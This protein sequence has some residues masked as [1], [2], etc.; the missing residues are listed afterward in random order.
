MRLNKYFLATT[1]FVVLIILNGCGGGSSPNTP[2]IPTSQ[3][4]NGPTLPVVTGDNVMKVTVNGTLCSSDVN[5]E[6]VNKP[7]VT[8]TVCDTTG[9]NCDTVDDV[10]LDTGSFG[11]RVFKSALTNSFSHLAAVTAGGN[12]VAECT[13]YGDNSIDWGPIKLAGVILGNEPVV[14]V[15][16]EVM[17]T[18]LPIPGSCHTSGTT[19]DTDPVNT[20]YKGILGVGLFA[21]DCGSSCVTASNNGVYYECPGEINCVSTA[22]PLSNQVTN[23]IALLP[24]DNNG[25][26]LELPSVKLGGLLSVNGYFVL[27]IG[28]RSN[29][30][31]TG[32]TAY[33][34]DK[35]GEFSTSFSSVTYTSFL[36]SGT[37]ALLFPG[38]TENG[39]PDCSGDYSSFFCPSSTVTL[40]AI[41]TASSGSSTSRINFQI[42]NTITLYNTVNYVFSEL[43]GSSTSAEGFDWGL[44]FFMGR[45]VY[46]GIESTSSTLGTGPYW[47]Y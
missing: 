3:L 30:T 6:Y 32:V 17:G 46:V 29:N 11:F 5:E 36:D 42:G 44:P 28:T 35:Y 33:S 39:L 14:S 18:T 31:P 45:N 26:I 2:N 43:G 7:C 38:S 27:G 37:N 8:V 16:I 25:A 21:Q 22:L 9:N 24:Q 19:V 40:S 47:A 41:N 10:L 12:P 4:T 23:P 1:I 20:G 13:Q 34:A 15:P